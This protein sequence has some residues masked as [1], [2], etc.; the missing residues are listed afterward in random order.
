MSVWSAR[1]G[2]SFRTSMDLLEEAEQIGAR[3]HETA[4]TVELLDA[5]AHLHFAYMQLPQAL[6]IGHRAVAMRE[7]RGELY[8]ACDDY[9]A[10]L[11]A[12]YGMGRVHDALE[13]AGR[14]ESLAARVGHQ[15]AQWNVRIVRT[16][17][18]LVANGDL[19]RVKTMARAD[20]AAAET[21]NPVWRS[22]N[23]LVLGSGVLLRR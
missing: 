16:M 7:R 12:L 15:P 5:R 23:H 19:A 2:E 13:V 10:V 21:M 9:W 6:D 22:F 8:H 11:L 1:D 4:L 18:D 17:C 14:L 3:T 20:L